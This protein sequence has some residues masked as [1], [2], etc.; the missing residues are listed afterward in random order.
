MN[1]GWLVCMG[2]WVLFI[3]FWVY[4]GPIKKKWFAS[5]PFSIAAFLFAVLALVFKIIELA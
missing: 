2:F 5:L 1:T 4:L 3:C